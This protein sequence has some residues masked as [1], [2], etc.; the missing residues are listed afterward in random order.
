LS[1]FYNEAFITF[2][3]GKEEQIVKYPQ[4]YYDT[5][6]EANELLCERKKKTISYFNNDMVFDLFLDQFQK[7]VISQET[8]SFLWKLF[9]QSINYGREDFIVAYWRKAHQ[10]FNLFLPKIVPNTIRQ[11]NKLV[12]TNTDEITNREKVRD[13]F[14]EFHYVLGGLLMYKQKYEVIKEIMNYT[15]QK[16]PK[17]VLVPERMEEVIQRYMKI[18][19]ENYLRPF[20]YE[21]KYP[22]PDI[23]GVNADGVIQMWIKRYLAILFLRQYTLHEYYTFYA[24]LQMPTPPTELSKMKHW[25]DQMAFFSAMLEMLHPKEDTMSCSIRLI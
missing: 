7:T 13:D 4:E 9:I 3:K 2:R 5:F 23:S 25:N 24:T 12:V 11:D 20:Y 18:S 14:L 16:P 8:Y 21:Q 19:E 22:F 10:L 6:F 15:Q 1:E 17:Y